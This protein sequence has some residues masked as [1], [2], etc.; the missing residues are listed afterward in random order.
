MKFDDFFL[1]Y[2]KNRYKID[3]IVDKN[4]IQYV[5]A[6]LKYKNQDKRIDIIRR[7]LRIGGDPIRVEILENYL[8]ILKSMFY[9]KI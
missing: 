7:F 6:I 8:S 4:V 5:S 1:D 9:I 2:M 3:K